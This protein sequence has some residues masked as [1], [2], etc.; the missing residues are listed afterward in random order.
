MNI[1]IFSVNSIEAELQTLKNSLIN[2]NL[3][4]SCTIR[5]VTDDWFQL[6]KAIGVEGLL[7]QIDLFLKIFLVDISDSAIKITQI[8]RINTWLTC[9]R[10]GCPAANGSNNVIPDPNGNL[11]FWVYLRRDAS[12]D[13]PFTVQNALDADFKIHNEVEGP[14]A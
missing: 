10:A 2:N 8:D 11:K 3:L 9:H 12:L 6:D 4:Q 14:C 7:F 13:P 1:I 5:G